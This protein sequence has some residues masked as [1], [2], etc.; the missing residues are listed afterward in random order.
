METQ[1]PQQLHIPYD[2]GDTWKS[3]LN[4]DGQS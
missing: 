2:G 1:T 3:V 4:K